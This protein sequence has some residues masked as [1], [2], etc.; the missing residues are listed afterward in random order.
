M[1]EGSGVAMSSGIGRRCG[2]DPKLLWLWH[3]LAATAVIQPLAWV[4]PYAAA[5]ALKKTKDRVLWFPRGMQGAGGRVRMT[6]GGSRN[7]GMSAQYRT[8]SSA[9][10]KPEVQRG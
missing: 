3:R 5:A 8:G 2:S 7:G 9:A 6:R 1:G 4:L 10:E